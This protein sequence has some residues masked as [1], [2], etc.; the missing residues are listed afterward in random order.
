[1]YVKKRGEGLGRCPR[2][3]CDPPWELIDT[4]QIVSGSLDLD[5]YA[6]A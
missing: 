1:M 3:G 2:K 4:N 5:M 6:Y